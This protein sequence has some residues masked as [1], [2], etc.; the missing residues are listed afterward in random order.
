MKNVNAD[1]RQ[2]I[3]D[4]IQ[5]CFKTRCQICFKTRYQVSV[6]R[7]V[8]PLVY[9]CV[10]MVVLFLAHLSRRLTR[11]AYR[12]PFKHCHTA[13]TDNT[14]STKV[15]RNKLQA[16]EVS[17]NFS[18]SFFSNRKVQVSKFDLAVK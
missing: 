17:E 5:I 18:I 14:L 12:I 3:D 6:F 4:G 11:R 2:T 8:D 1:G 16:A 10:W 15:L 7:T 9:L 13:R